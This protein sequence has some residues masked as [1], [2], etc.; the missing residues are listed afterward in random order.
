[1]TDELEPL[2]TFE[3][4]RIVPRPKDDHEATVEIA[5]VDPIDLSPG[6]VQAES[7]EASGLDTSEVPVI[8]AFAGSAEAQSR[9]ATQSKSEAQS[10]AAAA[11][12]VIVIDAD[13]PVDRTAIDGVTD[14]PVDPRIKARR[15][16]VKRAAAR[17]RLRWVVVVVALAAVIGGTVA[18]FASPAVSV[19][20]VRVTGNVYTSAEI[21]AVVVTQLSG[22]PMARADLG[23]ARRRL[24]VEPWV[25]RVSV[26]RQ[27]PS[28]VVIDLAERTP[29][30]SYL[31]SDEQW[32]I[33]DN[34]GV[35]VGSTANQPRDLTA[36]TPAATLPPTPAGEAVLQPL[37]DAGRLA[38]ALPQRLRP[39]VESITVGGDGVLRLDFV[40]K[41]KV[42]FGTIADFRAKLVSILTVIDKCTGDSFTTLNVAAPRDLVITPPTACT[43]KAPAGK[44]ASGTT[45]SGTTTSGTT[46]SGTTLTTVTP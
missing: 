4:V 13:N 22:E 28:T 21:L 9:D 27:W 17:R 45:A 30:A 31:A 7:S 20:H 32:Y 1:M 3:S 40:D 5:R 42:E 15:R 34:D 25:K 33:Y 11:R 35:V 44:T 10:K 26:R 16:S 36:I 19:R 2:E 6:A 23:A 43:G 29:V 37:I 41:A 38:L 46:T 39:R 8:D 12:S 14:T 24:A 18:L